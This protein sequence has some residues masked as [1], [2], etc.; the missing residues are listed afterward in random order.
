[1]KMTKEKTLL[2]IEYLV[3]TLDLSP[4]TKATVQPAPPPTT[5]NTDSTENS[6]LNSLY[7]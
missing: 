1:M 2:L 3:E 5:N 7:S 6:S 4:F